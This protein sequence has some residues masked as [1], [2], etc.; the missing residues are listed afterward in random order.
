MGWGSGAPKAGWNFYVNIATYAGK[1][2]FEEGAQAARDGMP[3]G[4]NPYVYPDGRPMRYFYGLHRE[5]KRGWESVPAIS[6][7]VLETC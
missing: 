5:W 6:M 4:A 2:G 1:V 3:V 7:R